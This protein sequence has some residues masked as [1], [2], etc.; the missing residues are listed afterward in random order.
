M[1]ETEAKLLIKKIRAVVFIPPV[2]Y[3]PYPRLIV[4]G[5][6]FRFY[7]DTA[8]LLI[9][10]SPSALPFTSLMIDINSHDGNGAQSPLRVQ[11]FL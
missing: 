1:S 4:P 7:T 5:C 11:D 9:L 10:K 2:V 8:V 3:I 6:L